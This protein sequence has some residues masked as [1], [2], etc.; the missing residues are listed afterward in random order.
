MGSQADRI[1]AV[2]AQ[3]AAAVGSVRRFGSR[4]V[5]NTEVAVRRRQRAVVHVER[6]DEIGR[7]SGDV[8]AAGDSHQAHRRAD[9]IDTVSE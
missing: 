8:R 7:D 3:G 4:R 1:P 9:I 6:V 2:V 5:E